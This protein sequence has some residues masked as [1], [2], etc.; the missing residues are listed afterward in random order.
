MENLPLINFSSTWGTLLLTSA[1]M[2]VAVSTSGYVFGMILGGMVAWA[3]L[4]QNI[5][6]RLVSDIYTTLLRGIPDLLIIYLFYFGGSALL[7]HISN[8][9]GVSGFVSV[10]AF[11]TGTLAVG[12]ASSAYQA[13][14]LRSAFL[15]I[16]RGELEAAR[17]AGMHDWLM[18][19]R[20]VIPQMVR[21]ALPGLGN[22]WQL[23]L[24]ESALVSITGLTELLRQSQIA[25]GSTQRPFDFYVVAA[26]L[27][28]LITSVFSLFFRKLERMSN[29]HL[30]RV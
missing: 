5:I 14:I 2:T 8:G 22:A 25:S 18:L 19:H 29:R 21:Y 16:N 24:K 30:R 6:L 7:T 12:V 27:Y 15:S 9:L 13:E 17:A 10:P 4:R 20:I 1:A 28:L 11:A 26:M 23:V 3:R